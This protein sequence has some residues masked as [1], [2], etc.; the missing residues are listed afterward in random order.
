[1]SER[2]ATAARVITETADLERLRKV[3]A[4]IVGRYTEGLFTTDEVVDL[5][6]R[7]ADRAFELGRDSVAA[8]ASRKRRL[9]K[10]QKADAATA[11]DTSD[12]PY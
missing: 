3:G 12:F 4:A 6:H 9:S 2:H 1:M 5:H 10:S 7:V 11:A 8:K